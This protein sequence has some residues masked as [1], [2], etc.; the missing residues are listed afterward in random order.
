MTSVRILERIADDLSVSGLLRLPDE[1]LDGAPL[2]VAIPGG[3]YTSS[4]FDIGRCSLMAR[5]AAIG[6]P[7]LALDRPGY[8]NTTALPPAEAS[9]ARNAEQLDRALAV[10]PRLAGLDRTAGVVLIGHSIGAAVA[11]NLAARRPRWS[12]LGIALSG[13]GL[14]APA[15]VA[16][17]W[18]SLPDIPLVSV[19]SE[20]KDA[21]MFGPPETYDPNVP[22]LSRAADAPTPRTE[23]LDIVSRWPAAM[24]GIAKEVS[25]PVHYRQAE[26]EK[27]WV[28][29]QREIDRFAAAFTQAPFVDARRFDFVGHCIDF[30]RAGAA[31]QLEQLGFALR[32]SIARASALSKVH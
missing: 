24:P 7:T 14:T 3:S 8:G 4:Y 19:P 12:L 32:C 29:D 6:L 23:L 27:L 9:I 25:V 22:A 17:A 5:A 16:G 20:A 18:S 28:A 21:L 31:F 2:I 26:F 1:P 11:V 15:E 10:M 30:H 13:I